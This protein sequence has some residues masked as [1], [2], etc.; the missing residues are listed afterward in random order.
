ML[1][2]KDGK[3]HLLKLYLFLTHYV[4]LDPQLTLLSCF[5]FFCT[6]TRQCW[7]N[8]PTNVFP[9]DSTTCPNI[10]QILFMPFKYIGSYQ[11]SCSPYFELLTFFQSLRILETFKAAVAPIFH[12]IYLSHMFYLWTFI[13]ISSADSQ[14]GISSLFFKGNCFFVFVFCLLCIGWDSGE[15]V[16]FC[17]FEVK[18]LNSSLELLPLLS[19]VH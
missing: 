4:L 15:V 7:F 18:T 5:L 12:F 19:V 10:V 11:S 16:F 8:E 14:I 6:M 17:F 3:F 13:F 9:T 1:Y 2:F